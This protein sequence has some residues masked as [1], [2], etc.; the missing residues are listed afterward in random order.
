MA[1][2]LQ[3]RFSPGKSLKSILALTATIV[4]SENC[5]KNKKKTEKF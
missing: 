4:K 3:T 2:K 1:Q 5:K